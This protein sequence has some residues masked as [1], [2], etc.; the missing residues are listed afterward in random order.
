MPNTIALR[1]EA[2]PLD[3]APPQLPLLS[4]STP[5]AG[6]SPAGDGPARHRHRQGWLGPWVSHGLAS[7]PDAPPPGRSGPVWHCRVGRPT[8]APGAGTGAPALTQDVTG[9]VRR[10][11]PGSLDPW[12]T[13][14]APS[15]L[16]PFRRFARGLRADD[17]AVQAGMTRPWSPGPS[18]GHSHRLKRRKRQMVGRATLERRARCL[19]LAA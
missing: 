7:L 15:L 3:D 2:C 18:A 9:L 6:R 17:A 13:R 19:R 10:R 12:L 14:A 1:L 16:P 4:A 11:Q 8:P 5:V